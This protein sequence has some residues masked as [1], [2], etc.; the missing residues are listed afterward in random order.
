MQK[1]SVSFDSDLAD[2]VR[3]AAQASGSGLSGWLAEAAAARL[4]GDAVDQ[5]LT[6]YQDRHGAFTDAELAAA[7]RKLGYGRPKARRR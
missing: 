2:A 4:R 3:A 7:D 1:L 5:Y 6:D